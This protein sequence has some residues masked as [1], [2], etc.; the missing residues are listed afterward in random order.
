M[1]TLAPPLKDR[2]APALPVALDTE[3]ELTDDELEAVVGGLARVH[4]PGTVI[5]PVR[6]SA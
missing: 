1:H 2:V 6:A 4:L 3:A 5:A